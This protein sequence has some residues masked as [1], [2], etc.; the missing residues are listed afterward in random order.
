MFSL[1]LDNNGGEIY[2][3]IRGHGREETYRRGRGFD[4]AAIPLGVF[5]DLIYFLM[6]PLEW[7]FLIVLYLVDANPENRIALQYTGKGLGDFSDAASPASDPVTLKV[8]APDADRRI[9]SPP[10]PGGCG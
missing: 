1:S 9:P 2:L 7:L 10:G 6:K 5:A 8:P 4:V 3:A